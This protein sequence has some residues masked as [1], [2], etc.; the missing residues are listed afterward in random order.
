MAESKN[1]LMN[2]GDSTSA[3]FGS[4]TLSTAALNAGAGQFAVEQTSGLRQA[5]LTASGKIELLTTAIDALSVTLSALRAL[6]QAVSAGAKS[7][8]SGGQKAPEKSSGGAE[9]PEMRKAAMA[10]DSAAATITDCP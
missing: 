2:A 1:M 4:I 7:E 3:G 8:S 10:M 6:P 5:L 9:L